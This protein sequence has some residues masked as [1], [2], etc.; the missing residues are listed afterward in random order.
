MSGP[1]HSVQTGSSQ[2][3]V[4]LSF[5][6]ITIIWGS[7]W[8][9][10]KD[11]VG[12]VPASWSITYRFAIA[13]VGMFIF[14]W[15]RGDSLRLSGAGM[16]FSV[17]V[18]LAQFFC[19]FQFVYRAEMYL[20]SGLV[21]VFYA[22]LMVPNAAFSRV[23]LK[24]KITLRFMLGSAVAIC[25]IAMLMLHEY[26]IA[27]PEGQIALGIMLTCAGLLSASTANVLQASATGK[28]Q[29]V[30]PMIA[31]AML[32]GTLA[33][34]VYSLI[35]FGA[36]VFDLRWQYGAGILYL[37]IMG[38]VVTFPL[39]FT[40]IRE[41]GAGRAAYNGVAVPVVA[42]ALSTVFEGYRWTALA[43]GGAVLAL[44]GLLIALSAGS[45]RA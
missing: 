33:D 45:K 27:P 19:N 8:L 40:L 25:G 1:D 44:A 3:K 34:A 16:R 9:V 41:L 6:I 14:A 11:Q 37:A 21:A 29:S 10:I 2:Q 28:A 30:V 38:S 5:I 43:A 23:F 42:M 15:F 17:L 31:W 20:T 22:L 26:R 32:W 13:C 39:Y 35:F 4:I 18:G 24:T 7:T 12:S 36:P